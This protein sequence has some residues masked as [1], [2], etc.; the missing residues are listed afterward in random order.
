MHEVLSKIVEGMDD[1]AGEGDG[2]KLDMGYGMAPQKYRKEKYP[3]QYPW[4]QH[5]AKLQRLVLAEDL[6]EQGAGCARGP[7]GGERT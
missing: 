1:C 4:E 2:K 5:L 7:Q 6:G 3:L